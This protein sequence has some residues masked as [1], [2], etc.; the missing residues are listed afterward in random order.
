MSGKERY[1]TTWLDAGADDFMDK[2]HLVSRRI[3]LDEVIQTVLAKYGKAVQ[4]I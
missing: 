2:G 4:P 3:D 1:R